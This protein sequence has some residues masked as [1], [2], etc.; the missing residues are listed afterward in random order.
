VCAYV[1]LDEIN[2]ERGLFGGD[3]VPSE[4][5]ERTHQIA[6][7]RMIGLMKTNQDIVLDDTSCFRWLRDG[8]REL[9]RKNNYTSEL[10]YVAVPIE[11]IHRRIANNS[12]K[13]E[14]RPVRTEVLDE[15]L[16]RFEIPEENEA[17]AVL[18][19]PMDLSAWIESKRPSA[20]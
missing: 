19:D 17:A 9:A 7:E 2:A 8:Y 13:P 20:K 5:W 1:S 14:R 4:E 16:R 6:S 11:E 3:G 18:K 12:T 15:H 10:I